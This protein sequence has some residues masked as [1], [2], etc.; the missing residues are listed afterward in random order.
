MTKPKSTKQNLR[1]K[2][3]AKKTVVKRTVNKKNTVKK[4]PQATRE[5]KRLY[6]EA[7]S[8]PNWFTILEMADIL[9]VSKSQIENQLL[10]RI[11][12]DNFAVYRR[13]P[14]K[15]VY[16]HGA[17]VLEVWAVTRRIETTD[18]SKLENAQKKEALPPLEE[19]EPP[20]R[21]ENPAESRLFWQ[22]FKEEQLALHEQS[23]RKLFDGT[24]IVR[25]DAQEQIEKKFV[26]IKQKIEGLA[27]DK[28]DDFTHLE[29]PEAFAKWTEVS[30]ELL[31]FCYS[32]SSLDD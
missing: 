20:D 22:S 3:P 19:R 17:S 27:N 18:K 15:A 2:A 13:I 29:L 28:A 9:H 26:D 10:P 5:E 24:L 21:W 30:E 11:Q 23:K 1:K 7:M 6:Q 32:R 8:S 12:R 16:M 25:A 4:K 14:G 31:R